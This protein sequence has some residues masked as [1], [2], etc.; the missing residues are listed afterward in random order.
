MK[1]STIVDALKAKLYWGN[2]RRGGVASEAIN[3]HEE[4]LMVEAGRAVTILCNLKERH[5]QKL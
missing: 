5:W 1:P 3:L 4:F 2:M